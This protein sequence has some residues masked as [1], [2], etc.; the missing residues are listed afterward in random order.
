MK[1]GKTRPSRSIK[2]IFELYKFKNP[3]LSG[4]KDFFDTLRELWESEAPVFYAG[5][6]SRVNSAA[7]RKP[8]RSAMRAAGTA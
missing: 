8:V 1:G 4:A 5:K 3:Q 7:Q 2:R 6:K